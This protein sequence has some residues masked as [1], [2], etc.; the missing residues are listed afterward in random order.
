[1][2][3]LDFGKNDWRLTLFLTS[4][5]IISIVILSKSL[6]NYDGSQHSIPIPRLSFKLLIFNNNYLLGEVSFELK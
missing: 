2:Y 3:S 1:M 4:F 5:I 6:F